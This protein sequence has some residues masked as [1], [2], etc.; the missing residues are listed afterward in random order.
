M[1]G[2]V[3][4]FTN[5]G[6]VDSIVGGEGLDKVVFEDGKAGIKV[7]LKYGTVTDSFANKEKILGGE[8]IIG[9][10]FADSITGSDFTD[11][12]AGGA[13]SDTLFGG[14]GADQLYGGAVNDTMMGNGGKDTFVFQAGHGHD[15]VNDLGLDD[16]LDLRGLGMASIDDVIANAVGNDLGVQ[17]KTGEDSSIQLVDVNIASLGNL[18]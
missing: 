14:N 16:K 6:A 10:S 9:T 5:T 1:S 17:I 8:I 12:L 7:N 3:V 4:T 18:G 2:G 13:G 11:Y 15:R